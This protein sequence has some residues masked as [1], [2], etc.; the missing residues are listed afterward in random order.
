MVKLILAVVAVV[1]IVFLWR[2]DIETQVKNG[3]KTLR[4]QFDDGWR[5]VPA[6]RVQG[7]DGARWYFDN[8]SASRCTVKDIQEDSHA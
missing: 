4:C 1:A 5:T 7:F 6:N 3:T 2:T 8:G